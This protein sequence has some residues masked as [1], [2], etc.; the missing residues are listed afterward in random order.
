MSLNRTP[1]E[2]CKNPDG[3][4]GYSW[5]VITG[6]L[7]GC[8]YCYARKLANTRLKKVYLANKNLAPW[9]Q[10]AEDRRQD[11]SPH[12]FGF[13]NPFY[14]RLWQERL[15]SGLLDRGSKG[16]FVCDMSDLFG[17]GIPE[18]WTRRVL[19]RIKEKNNHRFY[20]LTKQPQNL[21]K[22]SPF[23]DN[24]WVG[25]SATNQRQLLDAYYGLAR[26][27]CKVRFLS[28]EPLLE[29]ISVGDGIKYINQVIIGGQT[30][31]T[32][33]PQIEWVLEI[34]EACDKAGVKVFLKNN[35][36]ELLVPDALMDDVFWESDKAKLR[37]EM[38]EEG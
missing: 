38:L 31:P 7:N 25:V 34:V 28:L 8:D 3:T 29:H 24:A 16:I 20:L 4:Q 33:M 9:G 19:Q 10:F 18:D 2:W 21:Q 6:C 32:V 26:I 37:Q 13:S 14:P 22:F 1:I 27:E 12:D 17:I 5:N 11:L 15:N 23:P 35:L 36:R 30:K